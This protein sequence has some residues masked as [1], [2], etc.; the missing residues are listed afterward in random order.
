VEQLLLH[1]HTQKLLEQ[2][3]VNAPHAVI[4]SGELGAGKTALAKAYLGQAL[5]I[6]NL[7]N[8]PH[9]LHVRTTSNS[10][11]VD[12]IRE[13][14]Q[15]LQLKTAGTAT[16]RRAVLIEDAE[17]MTTE[18]QNALLKMLEEPPADTIIALT[19]SR[20]GRLAATVRSR[21]QQIL[22][23]APN[24]EATVAYF[25]AAGHQ[26]QVVE[27]LYVI[28]NGQVGLLAALLE[29]GDDHV[30]ASKISLAKELYGQST[31][32]RLTRVDELT[33]Q[34]EEIAG[35][36]YAC[37]RICMSALEQAAEKGQ[38][39][40]IKT[41]HHQLKAVNEAENMLAKAAP[42]TKLLLTNLFLSM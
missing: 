13:V 17:L 35:L 27:R 29:G 39:A 18:S 31:F 5:A 19:T 7:E 32:E 23:L 25:A 12:Q 11:G 9:Y 33:K 15:F 21:G 41:W 2:A 16:K 3:I 36:L 26:P 38:A 22:V 20:Y 28:S 37:K 40:A 8:H 14:Q 34:R 6:S 42:N 30:L 24:K 10:I 1:E 4:F